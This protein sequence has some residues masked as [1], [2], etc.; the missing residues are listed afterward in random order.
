MTGLVQIGDS[1]TCFSVLEL[2]IIC[3]M[4]YT[5]FSFPELRQAAHRSWCIG[6]VSHYLVLRGDLK[7]DGVR[8]CVDL[9]G[10][11][12]ADTEL[13]I[14]YVYNLKRLACVTS[15]RYRR[16]RHITQRAYGP[17]LAT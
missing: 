8:V 6:K 17:T 12:R 4:V 1:Q 15:R 5:R 2:R 7:R 10:L 14:I 3:I 13:Y 9:I 16:D 11:E